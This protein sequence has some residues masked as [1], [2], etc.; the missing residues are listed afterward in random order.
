[1]NRFD[2]LSRGSRIAHLACLCLFG[3]LI[4]ALLA[5]GAVR[6]RQL[7]RHGAAFRIESLYHVDPESELRVP[8]ARFTSEK[9]NINSLVS[10]RKEVD[11]LESFV[12]LWSPPIHFSGGGRCERAR[13]VASTR[14]QE[15]S[16]SER[17]EG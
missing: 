4:I 3:L 13:T 11:S 12:I 15:R 1:M 9:I 16:L 2:S 14:A 8:V 7:L 10:V 17:F 5:E 6:V